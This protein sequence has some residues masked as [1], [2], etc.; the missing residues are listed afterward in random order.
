MAALATVLKTTVTD[1]ASA[2][3]QLAAASSTVRDYCHWPISRTGPETT[4][5]DGPGARVLQLPALH[6][7][8]IDSIEI[9]GVLLDPAAYRWSVIGLV[10]RLDG[11]HWPDTYQSISVTWTYGYESVPDSIV[12]VVCGMAGRG[13]DNPRGRAAEALGDYSVTYSRTG[14]GPALIGS[15]T[16]ILDHYRLP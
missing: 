15:D 1:V 5:L 9:D 13:L 10:K 4:V 7:V 16:A 12:A 11:A 14:A 6:V 8:D 2:T 3:F